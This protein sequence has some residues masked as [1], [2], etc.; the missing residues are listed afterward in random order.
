MTASSEPP[1]LTAGDTGEWV[2]ELQRLLQVCG[3]LSEP[4]TGVLDDATVTA[5]MQFQQAAGLPIVDQV[6]TTLWNHLRATEAAAQP[7]AG[8]DEWHWDGTQWVSPEEATTGEHTGPGDPSGWGDG[9][10]DAD[11]DNGAD[12]STWHWDGYQWQPIDRSSQ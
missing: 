2:A 6:D 8:T 7:G 12:E 5:L 9:H 3:Q 10:G 4:T 11:S 1:E